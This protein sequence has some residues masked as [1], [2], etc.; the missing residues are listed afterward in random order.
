MARRATSPIFCRYI[1]G[2]I[3]N[4]GVARAEKLPIKRLL[5]AAPDI[6]R[7]V[8]KCYTENNR[9]YMLKLEVHPEEKNVQFLI[10]NLFI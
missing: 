9:K 4:A 2:I 1:N 5:G 7:F 8:K 6:V 10:Y 3:K